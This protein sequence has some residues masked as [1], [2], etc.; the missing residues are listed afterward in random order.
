MS[1]W[2]NA[3]HKLQVIKFEKAKEFIIIKYHH[4]SSKKYS[5]FH[6]IFI[7]EKKKIFLFLASSRDKQKFLIGLIRF[8]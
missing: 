4:S 6:L 8:S 2:T 3:L 5:E 7:A 1:T